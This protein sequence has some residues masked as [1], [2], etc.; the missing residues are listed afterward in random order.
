MSHGD[1]V[2]GSVTDPA[3]LVAALR[4]VG[5]KVPDALRTAILTGGVGVV[6]PLIAVANEAATPQT[7]P[8]RYGPAHAL[9]LLEELGAP[10]AAEGLVPLFDVDDDWLDETLPGVYGSL[11]RAALGPLRSLLGDAR[12]DIWRRAR[13]ASGL[14]LLAKATPALRDDV[15]GA[16]VA[17]LEMPTLKTADARTLNAIV[18]TDLLDVTATQ[19][20][21]AIERAFLEQRVD[22]EVVDPDDVREA[23]G[24]PLSRLP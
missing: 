12:R 24:V 6:E 15:I 4:T 8:A 13:A 22:L 18:I 2:S 7:G 1:S 11:G 23:L 19:A 9:A 17:H 21:P 10:E 20:A 5:K 3:A 14:A 16:L